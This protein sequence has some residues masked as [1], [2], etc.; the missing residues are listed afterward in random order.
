MA[1][2]NCPE[3]KHEIS[4]KAKYCIHC[5]Y[6]LSE[7]TN[8]QNITNVKCPYCDKENYVLTE[9]GKHYGNCCSDCVIRFEN[10]Y[11]FAKGG[12][13][14]ACGERGCSTIEDTNKYFGFRCKKCN[15]LQISIERDE[16]GVFK[17]LDYRGR[18]P[19]PVL[20]VPDKSQVRC[21]KCNSTQ[22]TT[23]SRGYSLAWGF[24]GAGKTVNR[25]AKCGYKWEP[26]R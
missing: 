18:E 20:G 11:R 15:H 10:W 6:P 19:E 5:G 8:N 9:K 24:I 13:C 17:G 1:L 4:D 16:N 3:C 26:K 22:I 21:P 12:K 2:I 23:G 7:I 14:E 25:C